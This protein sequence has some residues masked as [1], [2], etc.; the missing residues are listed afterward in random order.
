VKPAGI[1]ALE[2]RAL[3]EHGGAVRVIDIRPAGDREWTIPGSIAVDAYDAVNAGQLGAL[4]AVAFDSRPAVMVCGRGQTAKRA[5][6]LLRARGVDALTLEGGMRAWST[7]WNT[8]QA[9]IGQCE[10]VQVRRTGKG[11]LSYVVASDGS[12]AV[13]D[14][15]VAPEVYAELLKAHGWTLVAVVDTHIHADHLSRSRTLAGMAGAP[16]YLPANDRVR[17]D[18]RPLADLDRIPVGASH[19]VAWHTPGHTAESTTYVLDNVAAFTGDT[20]F[21]DGVGRP[22]L[23]GVASQARPNAALLHRSVH[24]L[25]QL[26]PATRRLPGHVAVAVPFDN[27]L[28]SSTI[29]SARRMPLLRVR[30]SEFVGATTRHQQPPPPNHSRIIT[31]NE[32]GEW[33]DE[34]DD[35]EAGANRC[36]VS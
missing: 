22:D 17:F 32:L 15:S 16:L 2:L 21:V 23:H 34:A 9:T 26:P 8:A 7:A 33:P 28:V 13:I 29:D 3:L 19:L 12:A 25:L 31:A 20:L 10:V 24:R 5:T 35:L 27:V 30:E 18:F 1:S 11:C 4:E 6:Q 36:A 14:A